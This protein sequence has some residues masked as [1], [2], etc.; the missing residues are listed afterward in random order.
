VALSR[1]PRLLLQRVTAVALVVVVVPVLVSLGTLDDDQSIVVGE[2]SP[3]TVVADETIRVVDEEA[4]S[5]ARRIAAQSVDPVPAFDPEARA[6]IVEDAR[7]VF[8]AARE[9]RRRVTVT[10][11][12]SEGATEGATPQTVQRQPTV[13]EQVER[14]VEEVDLLDEAGLRALAELSTQSLTEVENET[15]QLAQELAR[16]PFLPDEVESEVTSLLSTELAVRSFPGETEELVV[17]PLIR[18]VARPTQQ[19]DPDATDLAEQRAA[20]AVPEVARTFAAGDPIVVDGDTVEPLEFEALEQLNLQSAGPLQ[21]VLRALAAMVLVVAISAAYLW[22]MQPNVWK[23]GRKILLLAVIVTGYAAFVAG[24][25]LLTGPQAVGWWYIVPAGALAMLAAIMVHPVVGISTMLPA[26]VLVLVTAPVSNG[27]AVYV[28]AT[29]LVTVPLVTRLGSRGD[30]RSATLRAG[31]A[32]PAI[33]M[34]TVAVFGPRDQ[35]PIAVGAAALSGLATAMLVQGVLPFMETIFRLPTVTALLDLNDRNH[36]LLRELETKAIGSYNHSVMVASLVERA[37]RQIGANALLGSV[38][39]LYHDIGKVRR[40]HF[41]IENQ[42][43]IANP[44]DDLDPDISAVIIQEHVVDGVKMARE[45]RLPP[46]VVAAIGSH[47]GTMVVSYFYNQAVEAA[48]GPEHVDEDHFRYKGTK[49]RSKEAAILVIAD[50][51]EATTR[52]MAMN[53][54]TLPRED[55]E[56]TVDRL[57]QERLDDGQFDECDLT[58]TEMRQVRDSI[59]EALVGIYHP[60]I[61]YPGRRSSDR[62]AAGKAQEPPSTQAAAPTAVGRAAD[63]GG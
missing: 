58:F 63:R 23:S 28:A 33:A 61:A 48:G 49:P 12:P 8:D 62:E 13:D 42:Q 7:S 27:V 26:V 22:R 56:S 25:S 60:R 54:G 4:T 17:D 46:E 44:H 14:L 29:T 30:L 21:S 53:R 24:V 43:G 41:F 3:R 52:S 2:P 40:P 45:Y 31:V 59:V 6:A 37:C 36:P 35:F 18:A 10:Q 38:A 34:V 57:L 32:M 5:E 19:V 39:S 50:C 1:T 15:V 16:R 11:A 47:H 20:E 55:I 9:A 51:S